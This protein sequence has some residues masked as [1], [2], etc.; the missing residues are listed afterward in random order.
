MQLPKIFL[1]S[2]S[3]YVFSSAAFAD[4]DK[5]K[6]QDEQLAAKVAEI[7]QELEDRST[8]K[9]DTAVGKGK[10]FY[11]T[12]STKNAEDA[13]Y[14][15]MVLKKIE[16]YGTDHFP[17]MNGKKLYGEAFMS[18]PIQENGSIYEKEGG[19]RVEVSS[20][21][22]DLDQAALRIARNSAPFPRFFKNDPR[23]KQAEVRV[24]FV[25]F[26]FNH[27]KIESPANEAGKNVPTK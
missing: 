9:S 27:E 13:L 6:K 16:D 17:S 24:I 4:P 20:G 21:N 14:Y 15:K 8:A 5:E 25:R 22:K 11:L 7:A 26:N 1:L 23:A 19:I 12:P 10:K 2:L 3:L 18:I